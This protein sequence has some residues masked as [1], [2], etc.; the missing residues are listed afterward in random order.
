MANILVDGSKKYNKRKGN[1]Q[2]KT[3]GEEDQEDLKRMKNKRNALSRRYLE[4]GVKKEDYLSS[5]A[6]KV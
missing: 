6:H 1:R 4:K 5:V 2:G 3:E